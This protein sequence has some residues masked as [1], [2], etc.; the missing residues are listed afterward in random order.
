MSVRCWSS[1]ALSSLVVFAC[2][3]PEDSADPPGGR[4]PVWQDPAVTLLFDGATTGQD[5][6]A[7]S[8]VTVR[9]EGLPT[10]CG[11]GAAPTLRVAGDGVALENAWMRFRAEAPPADEFD[12]DVGT[13]PF[14][15]G[16]WP[17]TAT[18]R[19]AA[20]CTGDDEIGVVDDVR[21]R[22]TPRSADAFLVPPLETGEVLVDVALAPNGDLVRLIENADASQWRLEGRAFGRLRSGQVLF[23]DPQA[24]PDRATLAGALRFAPGLDGIND[25][26]AWLDAPGFFAL[27]AFDG[28]IRARAPQATDGQTRVIPAGTNNGFIFDA[29]RAATTAEVTALDAPIVLE[30]YR[31]STDELSVL[32][33]N[34]PEGTPLAS[35]HVFGTDDIFGVGGDGALFVLDVTTN[36]R[37]TLSVDALIDGFGVGGSQQSFGYIGVRDVDGDLALVEIALP[38]LRERPLPAL[39]LGLSAA[40]YARRDG[41]DKL[42]FLLSDND[43]GVL[44]HVDLRDGGVDLSTCPVATPADWQVGVD[45]WLWKASGTI[46]HCRDGALVE[47][48]TEF[49][50][51]AGPLSLTGVGKIKDLRAYVRV[52]G[53]TPDGAMHVLHLN[54]EVLQDAGQ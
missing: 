14:A 24:V 4:S 46:A 27:L 23:Q 35:L 6:L 32:G 34:V 41:G 21:I 11:A 15:P 5:G 37:T 52:V 33:L 30:R 50:V 29:V 40:G 13:L 31:L 28:N 53:T 18:V 26:T 54:E 39:D 22:A 1:I 12:L 42:T 17:R 20:T 51:P 9:A 10:D 19:V 36:E 25:W 43:D 48:V 38:D 16:A 47:A 8:F 49:A 7:A 45:G 44:V 3:P 2:S